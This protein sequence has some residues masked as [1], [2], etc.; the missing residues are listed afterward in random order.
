MCTYSV[1]E[2]KSLLCALCSRLKVMYVS[3]ELSSSFI[4]PHS[5]THTTKH[6]WF[7]EFVSVELGLCSG[8][9]FIIRILTPNLWCKFCLNS[10]PTGVE[11]GQASYKL[12]Y[13][14]DPCLP[15]PTTEN[16]HQW[17]D[18]KGKMDVDEP[19][20][21][22]ESDSD[23]YSSNSSSSSSPSGLSNGSMHSL[24]NISEDN[25]DE[26]YTAK[27]SADNPPYLLKQLPPPPNTYIQLAIVGV[28]IG[29]ASSVKCCSGPEIDLVPGCRRNGTRG[30]K[31]KSRPI[32]A[33]LFKTKL[34]ARGAT[35]HRE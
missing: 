27:M 8:M 35:E 10:G 13:L 19:V 20:H 22:F 31:D 6:Q 18:D 14:S 28:S 33:S 2:L 26:V 34:S 4:P 15:P 3:I 1:C 29:L 12:N 17:L 25:E 32:K 21:A 16:L 5:P 23:T 9:C 7:T 24:G 11:L 30:L